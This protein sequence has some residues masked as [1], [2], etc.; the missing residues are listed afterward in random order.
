VEKNADLIN[1]SLDRIHGGMKSMTKLAPAKFS[2]FK[3]DENNRFS[4]FFLCLF[5]G[6]EIS[7]PFY[8]LEYN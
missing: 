5:Q 4:S 1:E 3:K 6:F 2:Y 8:F 7:K